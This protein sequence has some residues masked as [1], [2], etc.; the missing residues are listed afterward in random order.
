MHGWR[1]GWWVEIGIEGRRVAGQ[2]AGPKDPSLSPW[3]WLW[4]PDFGGSPVLPHVSAVLPHVHVRGV[5][6][7]EMSWHQS[8]PMVGPDTW[9]LPELVFST[10]SHEINPTFCCCQQ[11]WDT[12]APNQMQPSLC[13]LIMSAMTFGR[14]Q[15]WGHVDHSLEGYRIKNSFGRG[16]PP[17]CSFLVY[18]QIC[19]VASIL[20]P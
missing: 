9:G 12:F 17:T 7:G 4:D 10:C 19:H 8:C 13:S 2:A 1:D 11:L 16:P 5:G 6:Y 15:W 3:S 20:H 18:S 14:S